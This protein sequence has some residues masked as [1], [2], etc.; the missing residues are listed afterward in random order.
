MNKTKIDWADRTWNPVTGCYNDCTY[1]YARKIAMR[2]CNPLWRD[3]KQHIDCIHTINTTKKRQYPYPYGFQPTFH[4]Y[5]LK[6]P[7]C[8]KEPQNIFVCSMADLF[9]EWV[10]DSWIEEVFAAAEKAPQHNYL[11]LTKNGARYE[12][13]GLL[14][15]NKNFWYG[16]T[17]TGANPD[18]ERGASD[19]D[20]TFLSIEPL[21]APIDEGT[22]GAIE[23]WKWVIVGAETGNRK[24]K[25]IPKKEWI[26]SIAEQCKA[27]EVPIFMK[28]SL[29]ELMGEDFIQEWPEGLKHEQF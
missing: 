18:L 1:C 8:I 3:N 17:R 4:G 28:E 26:M 5:R 2:F 14:P 21:L 7:S 24:G 9:G 29:K 25:I 15:N 10:P 23:L 11:F 27:A 12:Q 13:I 16:T 19:N 20:N 6:Q 22:L